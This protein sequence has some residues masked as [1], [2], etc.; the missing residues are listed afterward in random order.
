MRLLLNKTSSNV[1]KVLQRY[2]DVSGILISPLSGSLTQAIRSKLPWAVDNGSFTRFDFQKFSNIL[3]FCFRGKA[4]WVASPD[5][6]ANAKQTLANFNIWKNEIKA[7]R[8]PLAFVAQDGIED[9]EIPWQ[10]FE[11]LF[12]GGTTEFKLSN[13]S[14]DLCL[15][16][17]KQDKIVHMGRVNSFSRAKLAFDWGVD[18]VDGSGFARF[19]NAKLESFL[20]YLQELDRG[21]P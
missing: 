13:Q 4:M 3:N 21:N 2:A 11:C 6:V 5:V 7:R 17:K 10:E 8:I 18:S 12:I 20:Q 1:I 9:I 16:A 15:E 14:K 19:E